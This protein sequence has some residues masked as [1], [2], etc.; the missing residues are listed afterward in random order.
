MPMQ[1]HAKRGV[2]KSHT[3]SK[4]KS[5]TFGSHYVCHFVPEAFCY[6]FRIITVTYC[7]SAKENRSK[8]APEDKLVHLCT[9]NSVVTIRWLKERPSHILAQRRV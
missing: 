4:A 2:M 7:T 3:P 9:L 1:K 5:D 8:A 6:Q